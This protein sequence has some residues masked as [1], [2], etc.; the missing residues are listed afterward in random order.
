MI[1]GTFCDWL[2]N[3]GVRFHPETVIVEASAG[4][5]SATPAKTSVSSMPLFDYIFCEFETYELRAG[6]YLEK[7]AA[8]DD[9]KLYVSLNITQWPS[10]DFLLRFS[11][12]RQFFAFDNDGFYVKPMP[13]MISPFLD[14]DTWAIDI[15]GDAMNW[16]AERFGRNN[17]LNDIKENEIITSATGN[18]FMW[19]MECFHQRAEIEIVDYSPSQIRVIKKREG[20]EPSPYF[21]IIAPGEPQKR[22]KRYG[23]GPTS[24]QNM[25][26]HIVRGHFRHTED[27]PIEHFNGTFWI[28]AHTRGDEKLGKLVKHYKIRLP[29]SET[30]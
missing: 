14:N 28:A 18:A 29:E 1:K 5:E 22:Y 17:V 15:F 3:Q 12:G 21:R 30:A 26:L 4:V 16:S 13:D 25:P 9:Y 24:I 19:A 23:Q 2:I 6:T 7:I 8:T 27:H 10:R 11:R 20:K